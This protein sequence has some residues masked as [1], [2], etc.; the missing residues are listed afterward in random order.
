MYK[1]QACHLLHER[2][3]EARSLNPSTDGTGLRSV[4]LTVIYQ[5]SAPQPFVGPLSLDG[6]VLVTHQ[7]SS[8]YKKPIGPCK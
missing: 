6:R 3:I 5:A 1:R 2:Q 7:N 4:Q 8:F